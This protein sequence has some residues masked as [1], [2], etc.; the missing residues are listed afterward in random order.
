MLEQNPA[1]LLV[2]DELTR[3]N[4]LALAHREIAAIHVR[5]FYPAELC[6]EISDRVIAHD[7]LEFYAKEK[8]KSVA[9]L[10]TPHADT[11][12][13]PDVKEQ[14]HRDAVQAIHETRAIFAPYLAPTDKLKLLLQETWPTGANLQH[15]DGRKCFSGAVRVFW[16]KKAVFYPHYDRVDEETSAPELS[17]MTE[18]LGCNIY[19][20]TPKTGGELQMWLREATPV[21]KDIIREVEGLDIDKIEPPKLVLKPEEGDMIMMST[22]LLHA[23]CPSEDSHRV[24]QGTFIGVHGDNNPL[25]YWS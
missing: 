6:E 11:D 17:E 21:E 14:Y 24:S 23:V 4:L 9:R 15:L 16:P 25:T 20:R 10:H 18:Q 3:E 1:A 19:L 5:G 2:A 8:V 13:R 22:R 7:R 12:G